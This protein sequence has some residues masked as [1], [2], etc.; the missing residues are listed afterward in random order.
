VANDRQ[1]N[2]QN[3]GNRKKKI[4][5][6]LFSGTQGLPKKYGVNKKNPYRIAGIF[7]NATI[8]ELAK[9]KGK[10]KAYS[11]VGKEIESDFD[12][13][14]LGSSPSFISKHAV[15]NGKYNEYFIR[16]ALGLYKLK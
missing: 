1:E 14:F 16:V 6:I 8:E 2:E 9:Q 12:F 13:Q 15:V 4:G 5:W 11:K 10:I 3:T 7:S